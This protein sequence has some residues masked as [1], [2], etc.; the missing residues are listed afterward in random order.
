MAKR[1]A[2]C[3]VLLLFLAWTGAF[4]FDAAA[5][6]AD[7]G[8]TVIRA[9]RS[10][11]AAESAPVGD[12]RRYVLGSGESWSTAY[13]V[14]DKGSGPVVMVVAGLH[15]NE[16]AGAAAAERIKDYPIVRGKLIVIPR[17]NEHGLRRSVRTDASGSDLN[18]DFPR[19]KGERADTPLARA[20]WELVERYR[21]DWLMDLHEG[22]DYHV[23]NA[24]SVG[25]S[26]IYNP[27]GSK[28]RPAVNYIVSRLNRVAPSGQRFSIIKYP[29]R[30]GIA[31]SASDLLGTNAMIV[32]TNRVHD[33][34]SR[35][36]QYH[37]IAVTSL[38]EHLGML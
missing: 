11:A 15:G 1:L 18:R 28:I 29:V 14:V 12:S 23:R 26:V 31:R 37:E 34:M 30:G 13:Y 6:A 38:L 25:Q 33:P 5:A 36:I 7:M 16:P 10:E 8:T 32:E 2:S 3:A 19:R 4:F 20:I 27:K 22:Y 9:G 35:R 21:P 17:A 24:K